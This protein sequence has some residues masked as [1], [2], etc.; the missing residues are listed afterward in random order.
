MLNLQDVKEAVD[1]FSPEELRELR[2]YLD[3]RTD[4]IQVSRPLTP[5]ERIRRLQ[6][7]ATAIRAGFNDEE[8]DEIEQAMN[9]ETI[10]PVDDDG[11]PVL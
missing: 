7:A 11:F 10:E 6:E 9:A 2:E 8:W 5:E 4:E 1:R 3:R